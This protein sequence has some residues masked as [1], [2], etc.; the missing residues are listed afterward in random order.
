MRTNHESRLDGGGVGRS[1]ALPPMVEGIRRPLEIRDP[2]SFGQALEVYERG[3]V[4]LGPAEG[5]AFELGGFGVVQLLSVWRGYVDGDPDR[6]RPG[7]AAAAARIAT[8]LGSIFD[9]AVLIPINAHLHGLLG[10]TRPSTRLGKVKLALTSP[11]NLMGFRSDDGDNA[12]L[13]PRFLKKLQPTLPKS[14]EKVS[15]RLRAWTSAG[16]IGGTKPGPVS[17]RAWGT[18]KS[19]RG[20][21]RTK[22]IE[23]PVVDCD[24][25][26]SIRFDYPR[27]STVFF[28]DRGRNGW[29]LESVELEVHDPRHQSD[30]RIGLLPE[31]AEGHR[32]RVVDFSW[33]GPHSTHRVLS[34]STDPL[35]MDIPE[36]PSRRDS[37][38]AASD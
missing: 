38:P 2:S 1:S 6:P 27:E 15:P 31:S 26:Y 23:L 5:R 13:W 18:Y 22:T 7:L 28:R 17:L 12:A 3:M 35:R 8:H 9:L 30:R 29:Q 21:E 16:S 25:T 10:G 36:A 34:A 37:P 4:R 11:G 14:I 32:D 20:E 19:T 33:R 24:T